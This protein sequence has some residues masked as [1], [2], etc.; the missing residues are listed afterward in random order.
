MKER[1]QGTRQELGHA[2]KVAR[3]QA[4]KYARKVESRSMQEKEESTR[5]ESMQEK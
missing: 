1:E 3:N 5:E 2:R 4:G